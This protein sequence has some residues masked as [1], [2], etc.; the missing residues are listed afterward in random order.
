MTTAENRAA[1]RNA[2]LYAACQAFGGAIG[3]VNIALG[4]IAG[5]Y[6]LGADKSLATVPVTGYTLGIALG[7]LP[8]AM[9]MRAVGR[10]AGFMCGALVGI[11]GLLLA[12]WALSLH[13]FW[14]FSA[15]LLLTGASGAFVQQ[16]RFAAADRGSTDFKAKAISWVLIGGVF[17]AI[18]GPQTVIRT[19]DLLLPVPFA[20]AFLSAVALLA[21]SLVVL[22]FLAPSVPQ[23][24]ATGEDA[25][26]AR[27]LGDILRQP[28]FMVAVLCG[29]AT[30][31]LMSLVMTAAPLAML[32]CGFDAEE[33]TLGIQWHV[34]AMF[35]PSFFTGHLIARF[36]KA[37]VVATGLLILVGCAL[38]AL[39]GIELLHFWGALILLGVGWNFGFIG[40]TA[41]VTETYRPSEKGKAQGANDFIL[42]GTV[43][44]ASFMS[45]QMLNTWGWGA[46]NWT[47]FPVVALSLLALAWLARLERPVPA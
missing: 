37:A 17:A 7:A 1:R 24:A 2:M 36:G 40:A 9:L 5:S 41:M 32:D 20:G 47:I 26:P 44:F 13:A 10:K 38:L 22:S 15:A 23:G 30:Y 4:G 19:K 45:G 33:S 27:P 46:V 39:A 8:A 43:A 35:V 25:A 34:L 29:T 11:A 12:A 21:A 14:L 18:L 16:Y 31:A 42:F 6:L 28:R 3:P